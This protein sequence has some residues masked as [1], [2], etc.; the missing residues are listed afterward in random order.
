MLA[1][2]KRNSVGLVQT[3]GVQFQGISR[4]V[5]SVSVCLETNLAGRNVIDRMVRRDWLCSCVESL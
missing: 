5:I 1:R 2:T 4:K 3:E